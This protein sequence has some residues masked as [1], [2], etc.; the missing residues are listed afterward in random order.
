M[1]APRIPTMVETISKY[2]PEMIVDMYTPDYDGLVWRNADP[3]PLVDDIQGHQLAHYKE[4]CLTELSIE[5]EK[6][7]KGGFISTA[8]GDQYF[9]DSDD[10]G[11]INLMGSVMAGQDMPYACDLVST[12]QRDY[13]MHTALQFQMV[14]GDGANHKLYQYQLHH[15]YRVQI[16]MATSIA[17]VA[18][19]FETYEAI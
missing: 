11:T 4:I 16:W 7:I 14:F 8:L 13:Y 1:P 18:T 2:H 15:T 5:L 3:L 9:Y 19:I 17:E 12:G 10:E 6:K